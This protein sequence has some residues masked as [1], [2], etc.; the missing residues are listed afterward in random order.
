MTSV[1]WTFYFVG[2]LRVLAMAKPWG[3][4]MIRS[5][6]TSMV[7]S[8]PQPFLC[9]GTNV[10]LLC[11]SRIFALPR[12][13][14]EL[15]WKLVINAIIL[16]TLQHYRRFPHFG[17]HVSPRCKSAVLHGQMCPLSVSCTR[18]EFFECETAKVMNGMSDHH[19]PPS[20]LGCKLFAFL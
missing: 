20:L 7:L 19:Q 6:W 18:L 5:L 15:W 13:L 11:A 8:S 12:I 9:L 4:C 2:L 1:S 14:Q 10:V 3:E 17:R 16:P